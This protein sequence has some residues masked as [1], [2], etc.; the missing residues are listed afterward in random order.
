MALVLDLIAPADETV[1]RTLDILGEK[2]EVTYYRNRLTMEGQRDDA[3]A[4]DG[5]EEEQDAAQAVAER[6]CRLVKT[7]DWEGP[8]KR[9][10][11]TVAVEAGD[12]VPL[13]AEIVRLIPLRLTRALNQAIIEA[14][15]GGN[16]RNRRRR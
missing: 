11:G 7:W 12:K 9:M 4:E 6:L 10:D 13:Q 14:E 5:E 2:S 16:A 1:T 3:D 8:L 15:L